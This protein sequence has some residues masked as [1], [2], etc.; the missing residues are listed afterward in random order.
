MRRL[1]RAARFLPAV[2]LAGSLLAACSSAR[3]I[4]GTSD[5]SCYLA[6]PTAEDAVG[7]PAHPHTHAHLAGVRKFTVADLKGTAP[8]LYAR[9]K[10][11][12]PGKQGVCMAAFTGHFS[13]ATVSKP[14]GRPAGSV[15]VVAVKTPGNELLGTVILAHVPVNYAHTHPF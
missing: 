12:L 7:P 4:Q 11:E 10:D 1:R 14:F 6:L 13:A 9:F 3:A 5:E 8:R 15:A 2:L